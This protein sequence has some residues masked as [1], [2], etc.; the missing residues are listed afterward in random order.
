MRRLVDVL[1]SA[2]LLVLS[3]PLLLPAALAIK[4]SSPGPL[5]YRATR[6][7]VEGEPFDMLK[8]R[9]MHVGDGSGGRIT[10]R[11]DPRVFAAGRVLRRTKLDEVP[12]LVNVIRGDMSLVGPR[13]EDITIV[14]EH[15]TAWMLESLRV[16]PGVT[17]PGSLNYFADESDLPADPA[18]AERQYLT[19]L[20][21]RKVALELVYVRNEST[22]YYLELIVRT[23]LGIAGVHRRFERRTQWEIEQATSYLAH[24]TRETQI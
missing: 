15:Y 23:A 10:A 12:Q 8:L 13:P 3:A 24:S 11:E 1:G 14:R 7:G 19:R 21:P 6:A 2:V 9:T 4:W 5:L 16:R 18:E 20:L 17:G 22:S